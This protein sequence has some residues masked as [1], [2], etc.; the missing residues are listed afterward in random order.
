MLGCCARAAIAHSRKATVRRPLK[1]RV[2]PAGAASFIVDLLEGS[3][4]WAAIG[5]ILGTVL[6]LLKFHNNRLRILR[7]SLV[8]M[9]RRPSLQNLSGLQFR[10]LLLRSVRHDIG[11]LPALYDVSYDV[12]VRMH[13]AC[14]ALF[15]RKVNDPCCLV[16]SKHFEILGTYCHR[17]LSMYIE[18]RQS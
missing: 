8:R 5:L 17:V 1:R 13:S 6:L 18:S 4:L 9:R 10:T 11:Q 3:L 7:R 15:L 14:L 2:E 16:F 12:R